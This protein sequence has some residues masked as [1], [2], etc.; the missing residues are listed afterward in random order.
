MS[1][2]LELALVQ[3]YMN[4]SKI[5]FENNQ[6]VGEKRNYYVTLEQLERLLNEWRE[7]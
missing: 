2:I 6:V 5:A 4:A 1:K 7:K 3:V